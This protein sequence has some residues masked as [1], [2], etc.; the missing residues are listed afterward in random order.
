ML[1]CDNLIYHWQNLKLHYDFTIK[2]GEIIGIIGPSGGGKSTLLHLIA[3]LL[4]LQAGII[5]FDGNDFT[6][7]AAKDRPVS[8]LFQHNN[9][10]EHLSVWQNIAIGLKPHFKLSP[11]EEQKIEELMEALNINSFKNR[12]PSELSG[13]QRQRVALCRIYLRHKPLLLLDEPFS[14]LDP[15]LR[16]ELLDI[17]LDIHK[18]NNLTT[19]LV[20]HQPEEIEDKVDSLMIIEASSP[21]KTA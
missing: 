4:P 13:G 3:G 14:S 9:L 21:T 10:F 7:A 1:I 12:K 11:Q 5:S 18:K 19:L 6:R 15:S 20:S 2:K 16:A 8:L 17:T